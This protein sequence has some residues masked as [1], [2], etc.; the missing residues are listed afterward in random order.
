MSPI[1]HERPIVDFP[2]KPEEFVLLTILLE[3]IAGVHIGILVVV[4]LGRIEHEQF[5]GIV[6]VE[7]LNF[8]RKSHLVDDLVVYHLLIVR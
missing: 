8:L 5:F 6:V 4:Y 3:T 7:L 1:L 2:Q